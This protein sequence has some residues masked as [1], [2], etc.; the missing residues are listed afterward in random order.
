[1][2]SGRR[3]ALR[4]IGKISEVAAAFRNPPVPSDNGHYVAFNE[5]SVF[6]RVILQQFGYKT[7]KIAQFSPSDKA[8][9]CC[10]IA[11]FL[12]RRKGRPVRQREICG[13]PKKEGRFTLSRE[14]D[15]ITRAVE[16]GGVEVLKISVELTRPASPEVASGFGLPSYN[17]KLI[18]SVRKGAPPDVMQLTA[19]TLQ[20]ITVHKLVE[21]N[22][23][24]SLGSSPAD[25]L[26]LLEPTAI[27]K[28]LYCEA[29]VDLTYG[30]VVYDYLAARGES[31]EGRVH[32]ACGD[33]AELK[34]RG[35]GDAGT[36]LT[37]SNAEPR[38]GII[39]K[40][41]YACIINAISIIRLTKTRVV[42]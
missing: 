8:R 9:A 40:T 28:G 31:I 13:Y 10:R 26:H 5:K 7:L 23:T 34:A 15:V 30:E 11:T 6:S 35:G 42:A 14:G 41:H 22:A 38:A 19:T 12:N 3:T 16:R 37:T 20:N 4:R 27:L 36:P 21:G 17:L 1:L 18:P 32:G 39:S 2:R 24:L 25:P 29:D 33:L